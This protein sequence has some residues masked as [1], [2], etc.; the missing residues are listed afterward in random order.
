MEKTSYYLGIDLDNDNA[1]ISYFQLNMK[2]PETVSTVAGSEVYQ[3]PLILAK[4]HGIG[5]W[6]IGEEAKRLAL[7]QG[8]EAVSGLLQAALAEKEFF[9]EGETYKAQE[10]LALY[11]KKLVYLAGKLGNPVIPDFLVITLEQLSREVTELFLQV[12]E[13][14]GIPEGKLTL[15]DRREGFYYFA[16]SQQKELWLHDV[17]LFDNRGDEVWCRRLERDQRTMPQLVTISEEQRNID[18]A[19]KDASFL[20]IVSEVTGGHIVSAVYLTGDGFD[21]EWMK[22]SLSFLC[23]GR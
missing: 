10:L 7:L 15:I 3:I 2:E 16:F 1:V 9:I 4:K 19:N 6:F 23:K 17:C 21:G 11:I 12:A 5:Q 8:E 13:R 18:R 22:E 14:I 20:K